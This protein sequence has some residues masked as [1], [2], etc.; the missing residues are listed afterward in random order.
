M[1]I[2]QNDVEKLRDGNLPAFRR[3]FRTSSEELYW[4]TV[5]ITGDRSG[6]EDAVQEAYLRLFENRRKLDAGKS[7]AAYLRK[8]AV[9]AAI[10]W[11]RRERRMD[12]RADLSEAETGEP[13]AE[14]GATAAAAETA[15]HRRLDLETALC[16]LPEIYRTILALRYGEDLT[17]AQIA[18]L[19]DISVPAVALRI[20]RGK[21]HL[22]RILAEPDS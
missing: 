2:D 15:V 10:D 1:E 6:A 22:R 3:L 12:I 21:A 19:L 4:L 9:H 13:P 5:R 20:K 14:T 18:A 17:Y 11:L 7:V 16:R 8:I